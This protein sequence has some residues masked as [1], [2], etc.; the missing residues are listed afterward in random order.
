MIRRKHYYRWRA[1]QLPAPILHL[2][3]QHAVFEPL[4]LPLGV[5]RVLHRQLLHARS[6]SHTQ[7]SIVLNPLAHQHTHRPAIGN[8]V[9]NGQRQHLFTFRDLQQVGAKQWPGLQLKRVVDHVQRKT[10]RSGFEALTL[11]AIQDLLL[12]PPIHSIADHRKR[13]SLA[14][15]KICAQRL[16]PQNDSLERLL[17]CLLVQI[18]LDAK[19]IKQTVSTALRLHLVQKP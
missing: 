7:G 17:Q 11:V 14:L 13:R 1:F 19:K 18:A 15:H 5:V 12:Q 2:P 4:P 16:V 3:L 6:L 10:R 8:D 9:M